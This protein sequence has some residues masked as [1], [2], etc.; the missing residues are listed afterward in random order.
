MQLELTIILNIMILTVLGIFAAYFLLGKNANKVVRHILSVE[1]MEEAKKYAAMFGLDNDAVNVDV[2]QLLEIGRKYKEHLGEETI[3]HI[4]E[5]H[6]QHHNSI[7]KTIATHANARRHHVNQV[8]RE[9]S[10]IIVFRFTTVF[11][12]TISGGN[13]DGEPTISLH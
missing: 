2:L 1:E 13:K 7:R 10:M 12:K 6:V 4:V 11:T 3:E 8:V 5:Q 9:H